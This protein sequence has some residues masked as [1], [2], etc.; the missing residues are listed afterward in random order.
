MEKPPKFLK[1]DKFLIDLSTK[2]GSNTILRILLHDKNLSFGNDLQENTYWSYYK[3]NC[4]NYSLKGLI[5]IKFVRNPFIRAVSCYTH[6]CH[7]SKNFD[8]SFINFLQNV[9][10]LHEI[11]NNIIPKKKFFQNNLIVIKK[12]F[13]NIEQ[14]SFEHLYLQKTDYEIN[15]DHII[16]IENLKYE[17]N[18]INLLYNV[19]FPANI[20]NLNIRPKNLEY[21]KK[22]YGNL[23]FREFYNKIPKDYNLFYNR[24]SLKLV[25][26]IYKKDIYM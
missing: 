9:K 22:D 16:K 21:I 3:Q 14:R 6:Y 19:K 18:K 11:H 26:Q 12:L 13:P 24:E 10:K 1:V 2:T 15:Y 5:N 4:I 20:K 7:G 23:P 25:F 8:F 17:I